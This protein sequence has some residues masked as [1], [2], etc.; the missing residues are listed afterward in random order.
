MF[1]M[2]RC[3]VS[4][5]RVLLNFESLLQLTAGSI[6]VV[7]TRIAN[8]GLDAARFKATLKILDLVNR[9]RLKRAALNVV[10]LNQIDMAQRSLAEV[11]E[12]LHLRI[13]IVDAFDHCVFVGRAASGLLG[14]K[15]QCLVKAQQRVFLDAGHKLVA[16]GLNSGV[17]RDSERELLWNVGELTN[18][19]NNAAGR[20]GKVARTNADTVGIVED[21]QGLEN[22]IVIGKRLALA[23][24]Y[25]ARGTLAKVV[26]YMKYLVNDLLGGQRALKAVEAGGAKSAAH[27]TAGLG[28]NADGQ[29]VPARHTNS[30]DRN[31]VVILEK[32]LARAVLGNLLGELCRR[33]EGKGLF[34]LLAES[35]GQVG[36]II[37][38]TNVLFKDPFNELLRAESG[39]AKF[40]NKLA[41][42]VL[43]QVANVLRFSPGI[44]GSLSI[45]GK[46]RGYRYNMV[47]AAEIIEEESAHAG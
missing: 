6:N 38:R 3:R 25:N 32:I 46:R 34:K 33:I 8:R 40:G 10:E 14:V 17:Q 7:A 37:K 21:A 41:D 36:H 5:L 23:H 31:A 13:S 1:H 11:A 35:L 47:S 45:L 24:E 44:H 28:G 19:W 43:A 20:H 12:C 2:K 16:R 22:L 30:L 26:G 15:L 29:L 42:I 27:A 39:L 4:P 9:R 18:A